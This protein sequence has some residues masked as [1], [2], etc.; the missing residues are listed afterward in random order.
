MLDA[1]PAD[2]I[3]IVTGRGLEADERLSAVRVIARGAIAR[4]AG[5]MDDVLR[6]VAGL[7]SFRR[8]DSRSAH[9]TSQGL[10]LRGL[11][12]NAA[13]RVIVSL[14]GVPQADPFGGWIAF[15]A[16]DPHAVDR[17]RLI[18]GGGPG[19]GNV[20][21]SIDIDSRSPDEAPVDA[22]A[23]VG[24]RESVDIRFLGGTRWSSGFAT[25]SGSVSDGRGFVPIVVADRG[26]VDRRAPFRQAS[27]RGRFVKAIGARSEAQF[28]LSGFRDRRDRGTDFTDNAQRGTDASVRFTGSGP[29]RWS[30]LG[31]VQ[32]RRF[33]S[34]FAA[35]ST[36][37]STVAPTLAQQVPARGWGARG[38]VSRSVGGVSLNAGAEWRR[39]AGETREQF[40]FLSG[41]ATRHREAGGVALTTGLFGGARWSS[42]GWSASADIRADRWSLVGGHLREADLSGSVLLDSGFDDR[43]GWEGSGRLALGRTIGRRLTVRAAGYRGWRL[44]TLNELYRPFRAGADA[45]AANGELSP[46]RLRGIE[47]GI[48]WAAGRS[49]KLSATLFA[50]RLSGA[51]ANVSLGNGPATFPMVGFVA[52]GGVYRMRQNVDALV[53]RGIEVDG[54]TRSGPWRAAFSYAYNAPRLHATGPAADLDGKRPAQIPSHS[55]SASIGWNRD[56]WSVDAAAR[57]QG[58]QFEDDNNIRRLPAALTFDSAVGFAI[59]DHLS[60]DARVENILDEKVI[61]T[62]AADG[63]RERALPRTLWLGIRIH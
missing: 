24:S 61:A 9:P 35:V 25:L 14:D 38:D 17:V 21:G 36:G 23:A 39:V 33:D 53:S 37:R 31:Y 57:F 60:L 52:A 56:R 54:E 34:Q 1:A 6:D 18:R 13:S 19:P 30:V 22:R 11:G 62:L 15:T 55:A 50:N 58:R 45:T 42:S 29:T 7:S 10:T 8:S 4:A 44:P 49:G 20:A 27:V 41:A 47:A 26:P 32:D 2:P 3:I 63:T 43:S 16:L 59:S 40:R 48:D 5:R 28:N 51:I 46:E 12:G